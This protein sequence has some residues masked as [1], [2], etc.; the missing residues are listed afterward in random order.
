MLRSVKTS[1]GERGA[2]VSRAH[3]SMSDH[4]N[5]VGPKPLLPRPPAKFLKEEPEIQPVFGN[6]HFLVF[7]RDFRV[8]EL[9]RRLPRLPARLKDMIALRRAARARHDLR[10]PYADGF[11]QRLGQSCK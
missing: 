2:D 6:W 4:D 1:Y 5:A 9:F 10:Y 3:A 11:A 7:K 8:A